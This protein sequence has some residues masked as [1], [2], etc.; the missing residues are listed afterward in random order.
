LDAG[1]GLEL[2]C[3]ERRELMEQELI[4]ASANDPASK[5]FDR[6]RREVN[7]LRL[8]VEHLADAPGKIEIPDYT[9]TLEKLARATQA[10]TAHIESMS[11]RP[12]LQMTPESLSNAII[13]AGATAR[14]ADHAALVNA[15][16]AFQSSE[17]SITKSLSFARTAV[18]QDMR[19]KKVSINCLIAGMVIWAIVP[20]PIARSLPESWHLP[21][22]LAARAMG[23]NAWL[24]GQ[25]LM[26]YAHPDEWGAIEA[27]D[28]A[29]RN[30]REVIAR[31][32]AAA[33]KAGNAKACSVI[34]FP[35]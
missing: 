17:Q 33:N 25:R 11:D 30:S 15:T 13:K 4:D 28:R 29:T 20:G 14:A 7:T 1:A 27:L 6:L 26:G 8:A 19:L 2:E 35:R 31:C 24:S 16:I 9:A 32:Q 34:V 5:A 18:E 3:D 10:N 21:E 12:G 23:A 22:R